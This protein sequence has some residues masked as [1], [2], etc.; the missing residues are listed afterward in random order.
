MT[1]AQVCSRATKV[2]LAAFAELRDQML[3][4]L[5]LIRRMAL[6]A[7]ADL[8]DEAP[9]R[10]AVVL[11]WADGQ[12]WRR[13]LTRADAGFVSYCRI[14]RETARQALEARGV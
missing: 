7:D 12:T 6:A 1:Q 11:T 13:T 5:P 8:V 10:F 4:R 14:M 2:G 3:R 9:D